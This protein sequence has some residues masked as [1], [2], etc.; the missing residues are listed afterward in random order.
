MCR[1]LSAVSAF[2]LLAL[3][4]CIFAAPELAFPFNLPLPTAVAQADAKIF[5][6]ERR[7]ESVDRAVN[8]LLN[9]IRDGGY[10]SLHIE[11]NCGQL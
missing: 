4:Q 1:S 5:G 8:H 6:I 2:N 7:T 9:T 11:C 10:L 3:P